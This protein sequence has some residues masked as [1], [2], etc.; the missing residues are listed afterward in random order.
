MNELVCESNAIIP[1]GA[2]SFPRETMLR[3]DYGCSHVTPIQ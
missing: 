2:S 1:P 3:F